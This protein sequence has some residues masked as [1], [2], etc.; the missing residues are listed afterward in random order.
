MSTLK[1]QASTARSN[2]RLSIFCAPSVTF[3]NSVP[4]KIQAD[5]CELSGVR[6]DGVVPEI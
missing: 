3:S 1:A 2:A 4:E 6:V 5:L